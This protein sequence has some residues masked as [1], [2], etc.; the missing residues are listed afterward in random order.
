M[1]NVL[2]G[3]RRVQDTVIGDDRDGAITGISGGERRRV[4]VGIG[5]VTDP[6]AL[7][8][9]EPTTGGHACLWLRQVTLVGYTSICIFLILEVAR[10]CRHSR[11]QPMCIN[12]IT[13]EALR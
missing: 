13:Q 4:S 7:F 5:L 11:L 3:L 9:D 1:L 2:Q 6:R 10:M 12:F 8:L